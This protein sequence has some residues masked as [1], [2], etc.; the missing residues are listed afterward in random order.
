M[1]LW[2]VDFPFIILIG[3]VFFY[4]NNQVFSQ[5]KTKTN[6]SQQDLDS[7]SYYYRLSKKGDS[8]SLP[9]RLR[10]IT[11]FLKGAE[12]FQKDSLI[13]DGLM[14]KTLL[15]SKSDMLDSAIL[16][17][18]KLYNVASKNLDTMY[19][20]K[21]S[22]KLG[23]YHRK[24]GQY[25]KAFQYYNEAFKISQKN[26]DSLAA[27]KTLLQMANI[28]DILGDYSGSRTTAIDGLKYLETTND[29]KSLSG[30]YHI[31]SVANSEQKNNEE[32]LRYNSLAI[33]L[34]T[35][36]SSK[37]AIRMSNILKFKNTKAL[38]LSEMA[39]YEEAL[40]ILSELIKNDVVQNNKSEYARVLDNLGYI[41]WVKDEE[42]ENSL[43]LL[44]QAKE[45][46]EN[47]N[48]IRGLFASNIHLT[49]YYL[50]RD[51][52][53]AL[54]YAD[55]AYQNAL[56]QQSLISILEALGFVFEL[57]NDSNEEAKV[58]NETYLKLNQINQSNREIYAV[59]KYENDKLVNQNLILK[60]KTAKKERQEIIYLFGTIIL[61]LTGG[62]VFYLLQQR[63]KREKI[64]DVYNAENRISKKIHDELANDVYN[65][66]TQM[67]HDHEILDK[68]EDIYSRTRD[69]S[70]ENSGF[71]IES[72]YSEELSNML[73]GY[74]SNQTK[75]IIK[76]INEINWQSIT[77]EKKIVIHR[78]LQELSV[79]MKKHSQA[80]LVA[81]AFK[82]TS[83][84]ITISYSDNGVGV[85]KNEIIY[86]NG[87][88]NV[89]NR[90]KAIGGLFIFDSE[91]GKGF[92]A[93]IQFPN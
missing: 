19:M 11:Y 53:R 61:L 14:Q 64:R 3:L 50:G 85:D 36:D 45:I 78:V 76:G 75:I 23:I 35:D 38:I 43:K 34:G 2:R 93:K 71:D 67:E 62:F 15:L 47:I 41:Q 54:K 84:K 22:T 13:Y 70:R 77:P 20:I 21:A 24:N 44:M 4:G 1:K 17:S 12:L 37:N 80:N 91:K 73:S 30:L 32:A 55:E 86:S 57:R 89:E 27:G 66:M 63:Y 52:L 87:L 88:Q 48:D 79:N 49:K 82:K 59:T 9:E 42:N 18:N 58:F 69:I 40:S 16:Y 8:L 7:I 25:T 6:F 83:K 56:K 46:R 39:N 10:Y 60:A 29:L 81:F 72:N 51:R 92:R 65:I 33:D 90:T 5:E 74:S 26:N 68:L 31:I 28:Q